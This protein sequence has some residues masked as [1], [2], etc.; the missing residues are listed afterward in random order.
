MPISFTPIR[1]GTSWTGCDWLIDDDD[2]L[3]ELVALVALGQYR[4]VQHIL[5][6][7]NCGKAAPAE[8]ALEGAR[9]LLKAPE[10]SR[11][12]PFHRDG[13][14][15]QV[16]AWIAAHLQGQA[17]LIAPPHMLHAEKGF[18]GLHVHIDEKAQ[19]VRSVVICEEK[20]TD[21]PRAEIR[22]SVWKELASLEKGERDHLL[23][24][25]V[26]TLLTT[27]PDLDVDQAVQQ[28]I[29]KKARAFRVAITI[30]DTHD[31]ENGRKQLF[32]GYRETVSGGVS[33][34]R[35]ETLYLDDL[36]RWMKRIARNALTAA[37]RMVEPHV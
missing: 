25:E 12:D 29:W 8:T 9:Q 28:I 26:S 36:R 31:S 30:G 3:A 24:A 5:A 35:A 22:D 4:H 7:T 15:F 27:R 17:S 37:E 2:R 11:A 23:T 10:G 14:L 16:M 13:W 18:D 34:R 19:M 33:R 32:K 1:N 6:E 20:A 21:R